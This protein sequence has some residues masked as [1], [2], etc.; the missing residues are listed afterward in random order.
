[1]RIINAIA[2]IRMN[3]IG[4]WTDTWFA[5]HGAV[6]NVAV[7]PYVEV[8]VLVRERAGAEPQVEVFAENYDLR[9][10]VETARS[11]GERALDKLP[12]IQA[13]I[14]RMEIPERLAIE[15]RVH[16]DVPPGAS[17]GTSAAVS[18]AIIGA[19]DLLT[20][21]RLTPYE[22]ARLA[23][24]IETED[25]ELQ[26]GV[27]DQLASA[28][29]GIS[30]IDIPHFPHANVAPIAIG[31]AAWWELEQRLSLIYVG[32]PHQ[33]SAVHQ[34]VIRDL[35]AQPS[36]DP[37]LER[38]RVLA[39]QAKDAVFAADWRAYGAVMDANTEVQRALHPSLVSAD[40][41]QVIALAREH[42]ALGC[43]VNG[44]GGDGGSVTILGDGVMAR[45]RAMHAAIA[46][47]GFQPVPIYLARQGLRVW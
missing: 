25:L 43:K 2:P 17:T 47:A 14:R 19:L 38:M 11:A 6:C 10:Q 30:L 15:V 5:G 20:P 26:S 46:A 42:G 31:N 4:G 18:V 45:K 13:A 3:D 9:F 37:R 1:M 23:H 33:S 34:Q 32:R 21:G 39:R 40:F 27:Q 41:E 29:G 24:A 8:Q 35:G 7:Y 22:V 12:L 16:S 44:A 36:A 28:F